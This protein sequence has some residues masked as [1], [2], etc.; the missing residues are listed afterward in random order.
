MPLTRL[1]KSEHQS[2]WFMKLIPWNNC[3]LIK[4]LPVCVLH[5]G[6]RRCGKNFL[7]L[8]IFT[9]LYLPILY[10]IFNSQSHFTLPDSWWQWLM[11]C[12]PTKLNQNPIRR[13]IFFTLPSSWIIKFGSLTDWLM[14]FPP[15]Q[16]IHNSWE[17]HFFCCQLGHLTS[18]PRPRPAQSST[19]LCQG[20]LSLWTTSLW[21]AEPSQLSLTPTFAKGGCH[22]KL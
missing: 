20:R 12:W 4:C 17:L 16:G 1:S 18:L 22:Q 15:T 5:L 3:S 13:L 21:A 10:F 7:Y 6:A 14:I 2:V 9:I 8:F 11:I 19:N